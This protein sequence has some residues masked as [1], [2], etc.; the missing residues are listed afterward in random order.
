MAG[1]EHTPPA[2]K[3]FMESVEEMGA[4]EAENESA[5]MEDCIPLSSLATPDAEEQMT[6]P[7]VGD[8]VNYQVTGKVTR[9]EGENAYV[10][11]TSINGQK[12]SAPEAPKDELSELEGMAA[13]QPME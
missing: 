2:G 5:G 4:P 8:E 12:V 10:Q 1:G 11:K 3:D 6:N 7:E 13:Q 9:I